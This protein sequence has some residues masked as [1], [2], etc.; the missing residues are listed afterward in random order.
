MSENENYEMWEN[1]KKMPAYQ[2]AFELSNYVREI[3]LKWDSF[4]KYTLGQQYADALDSIS[5]NLAEGYGRYHFKDKIKF[6]YNARGSALEAHDWTAK[7]I[8]RNLL[9][10]E[11]KERIKNL[12]YKLPKDINILINRTRSQ[13]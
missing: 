11:E 12:L 7:A 9:S 1:L 6:Y 8:R 3:V 10:S 2:N 5:A 4:D 13:M